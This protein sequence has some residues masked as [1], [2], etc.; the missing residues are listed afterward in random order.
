MTDKSNYNQCLFYAEFDPTVTSTTDS[1]NQS[2]CEVNNP[3]GSDVRMT[4][5]SNDGVQGVP[6]VRALDLFIIQWNLSM[7]GPSKVAVIER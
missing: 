7:G 6:E 2:I 3:Y 5:Q 1:G 4:S